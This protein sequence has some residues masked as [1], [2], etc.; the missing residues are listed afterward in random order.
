V[1]SRN[2]YAGF[3]DEE[4]VIDLAMEQKHGLSAMQQENIRLTVRSNNAG[5][6]LY[7]SFFTKAVILNENVRQQSDMSYRQLLRAVRE[8]RVT[9]AQCDDINTRT[10]KFDLFSKKR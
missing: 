10:A 7:H 3:Q 9:Q 8:G 6:R 5:L 1:C 4:A 2:L